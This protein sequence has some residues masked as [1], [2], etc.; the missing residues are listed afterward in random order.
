MGSS[1][2]NRTIINRPNSPRRHRECTAQ[3][4]IRSG[5]LKT[6]WIGSIGRGAERKKQMI[7][8]LGGRIPDIRQASGGI[9]YRH[10]IYQ[11]QP[12]AASAAGRQT[13]RNSIPRYLCDGVTMLW[14]IRAVR[15]LLGCIETFEDERS[16]CMSTKSAGA[17]PVIINSRVAA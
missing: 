10:D 2:A 4:K 9:H 15:F 1:L 6:W 5:Y 11:R 3:A 16:I 8:W 12:I 13:R 7:V 17:C 14:Y